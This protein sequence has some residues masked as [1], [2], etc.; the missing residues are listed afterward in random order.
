ME[1]YRERT[2]HMTLPVGRLSSMPL[3]SYTEFQIC[4]NISSFSGRLFV[5]MDLMILFKR[6]GF[7]FLFPIRGMCTDDSMNAFQQELF[8]NYYIKEI[9]VSNVHLSNVLSS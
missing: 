1:H 2:A 5:A 7:P 8:L 9:T 4:S 6:W 3:N